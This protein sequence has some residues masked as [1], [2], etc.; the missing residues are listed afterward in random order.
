[1][2]E[3]IKKIFNDIKILNEGKVADYIPELAKVDPN[4]FAISVCKVNGEQFNIGDSNDYFVYSHVAS[5][6]LIA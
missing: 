5:H 4:K 6:Y 1:M 3:V 2:Q